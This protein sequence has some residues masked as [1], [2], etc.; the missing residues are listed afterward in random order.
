MVKALVGTYIAAV[1]ALVA[2]AVSI[3]RLRC[4]GFG[5]MGVGVAW[6]AWVVAFRAGRSPFPDVV[7]C[8]W[9]LAARG[10]GPTRRPCRKGWPCRTS[11]EAFKLTWSRPSSSTTLR[12]PKPFV[13]AASSRRTENFMSC[14]VQSM[15]CVRRNSRQCWSWSLMANL[16]RSSATR[17]HGTRSTHW[18]RDSEARSGSSYVAVRSFREGD[19]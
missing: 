5:C 9:C 1:L 16:R 4:E 15:P 3:W 12:A 13:M 19:A 7:E 11:C 6:F 14:R 2:G 8:L 10:R 18:A 17:S